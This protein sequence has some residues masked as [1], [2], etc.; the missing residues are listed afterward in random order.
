[1]RQWGSYDLPMAKTFWDADTRA[2]IV[3]RV[4][5]LTPEM[6]PSWGKMDARR[7]LAHI[8]DAGK[9]ALGEIA[10]QPRNLP[11]RHWPLRELVI[12]VLPWPK[13]APTAPELI[14]RSA[15]DWDAGLREFD[16]V[17]DRLVAKSQTGSFPEHP[18]FGRMSTKT[19]GALIARHLDHH[20]TQFGA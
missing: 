5:S 1:M 19:W 10:A 11:I 20:L 9:M 14:R 16:G 15:D 13:G 7:M 2:A 17:V 4:H 12:Y 18:A 6:T 8:T 3:R